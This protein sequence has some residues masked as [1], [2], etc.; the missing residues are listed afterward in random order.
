M[1]PRGASSLNKASDGADASTR[2]VPTG[3]AASPAASAGGGAHGGGVQGYRLAVRDG[4]L[5]GLVEDPFCIPNVELMSLGE[6]LETFE[7]LEKTLPPEIFAKFLEA[8]PA[9]QKA[10]R[11]A[12]AY[13]KGL[14][15]SRPAR[16]ALLAAARKAP[17]QDDVVVVVGSNDGT[18]IDDFF[19]SDSEASQARVFKLDVHKWTEDVILYNGTGPF[20]IEVKAD[21][22]IA[23]MVVRNLRYAATP[24]FAACVVASK[25][26]ALIVLSDALGGDDGGCMEHW[27]RLADVR[28]SGITSVKWVFDEDKGV[29]ALH[30][31]R[32]EDEFSEDQLRAALQV[33]PAYGVVT[34][35]GPNGKP[36]GEAKY[37]TK[38]A[39]MGT[40]GVYV[41]ATTPQ[42]SGGKAQQQG[43]YV[44]SSRDT[45]ARV[46]EHAAGGR[47][48]SGGV[49]RALAAGANTI[50]DVNTG[51]LI[52]FTDIPV[53][54][55]QRLGFDHAR[56]SVREISLVI[57]LLEGHAISVGAICAAAFDVTPLNGSLCTMQCRAASIGDA[58]AGYALRC[59]ERVSKLRHEAESAEL[60]SPE[61]ARLLGDEAD[62]NERMAARFDE[63]AEEQREAMS[64]GASYGAPAA[65]RAREAAEQARLAGDSAKAQKH[66]ERADKCDQVAEAKS[67]AAKKWNAKEAAFREEYRDDELVEMTNEVV[68][69]RAAGL[70]MMDVPVGARMREGHQRGGHNGGNND[71]F[72]SPDSPFPQGKTESDTWRGNRKRLA[73]LAATSKEDLEHAG[74]QFGYV[75]YFFKR[76]TTSASG[77][78]ADQSLYKL[79]PVMR[80][81]RTGGI[82]CYMDKSFKPAWRAKDGQLGRNT[83]RD[84]P[85][86]AFEDWVNGAVAARG[87]SAAAPAKAAPVAGGSTTRSAANAPSAVASRG[88]CGASTKEGSASAEAIKPPSGQ[89]THELETRSAGG[90]EGGEDGAGAEGPLAG[91]TMALPPDALDGV[92]EMQERALSA[93]SAT[94]ADDCLTLP[95]FCQMCQQTALSADEQHGQMCAACVA[96]DGLTHAN[97]GA[98]ASGGGA[99]AGASSAAAPAKAAPVAGG[100]TTPAVARASGKGASS[101]TGTDGD[102]GVLA[103]LTNKP[104]LW[105]L[106][107]PG[108]HD[109]PA[110]SKR[111]RAPSVRAQ[112][113]K[114]PRLVEGQGLVTNYFQVK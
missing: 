97:G 8:N 6:Q 47:A 85:N 71:G 61:H 79:A 29:A 88:A 16:H 33:E 99:G 95:T 72:Q 69:R 58:A 59:R 70:S 41:V 20:P 54:V 112:F 37:F 68:A 40:P 31:R 9:L 15:T 35:L 1:L 96:Y 52:P 44:G 109:H 30:L 101:G 89:V 10:A 65:T 108:Q 74:L 93:A 73:A 24:L 34:Y 23:S 100:S 90:D 84:M 92:P 11:A 86:A 105:W 48:A 114:R 91:V 77:P 87:A 103:N 25:P 22:I 13:E 57:S 98:S 14:W 27:A 80:D 75:L 55:I 51:L 32:S 53:A 81:T 102:T 107:A 110:K 38:T 21:A 49:R 4:A 36:A 3:E 82:F 113:V 60:G 62:E 66:L 78:Q 76:T 50:D 19:S 94:D 67:K 104:K 39:R 18:G 45:A 83:I 106:A 63:L 28:G 12:G 26:G 17:S 56:L 7:N 64:Y 2:R 111:T 46:N 43:V 5:R 42:T